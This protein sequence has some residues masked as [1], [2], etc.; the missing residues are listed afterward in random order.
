MDRRAIEALSE[1]TTRL[2]R[3]AAARVEARAREEY[4]GTAADG[5]VTARIGNGELKLELHPLAK[6]RL[7]RQ[8]LGAAVVEAIT[9]AE[10]AMTEVPESELVDEQVLASAPA[11][12]REA[13]GDALRRLRAGR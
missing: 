4:V 12:F 2:I 11:P 5:L 3:S 13:F 8:A 1:I 7:D 10:R 9:E 6:R